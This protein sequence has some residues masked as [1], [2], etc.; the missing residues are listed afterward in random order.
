M[1]RFSIFIQVK[2]RGFRVEMREIVEAILTSAPKL[3]RA[4]VMLLD[5]Q[6]VAFVT[7]KL[8]AEEQS[9]LRR[10]LQRQLQDYMIPGRIIDLEAFPLN[11]NGKLDRQALIKIGQEEPN[12]SHAGHAASE[13][14]SISTPM[15]KLVQKTWAEILQKSPEE[16]NLQSNFFNVGGTSLSGI[17]AMR[18]LGAALEC[19]VPSTVAFS[20]QE[21][22]EQATELEKLAGIEAGGNIKGF[23]FEARG[24]SSITI[25]DKDGSEE[26]EVQDR[27]LPQ[28]VYGLLQTLGVLVVVAAGM[29]PAGGSIAMCL[30]LILE[31][32]GFAAL[33]LLPFVWMAGS[34]VHLLAAFLIKHILFGGRL[35]PG[36]YS[37]YGVTFLRWWLLRKLINVTRVWLWYVNNT[38]LNTAAY[39]FLGAHLESGVTLDD[40]VLEDLDLI[41]IEKN[42]VLQPLSSLIPGEIIGDVLILKP[43]V[44]GSNSKLEPRAAVLGGGKVGSN[45][46]V[47]PWSAVTSR[48]ATKEYVIMHGSPAEVASKLSSDSAPSQLRALYTN[49]A[50]FIIGQVIGTYFLIL[51]HTLGFGTSVAI[52]RVSR[53]LSVFFFFCRLFP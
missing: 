7:P 39:R 53:R 25:D 47:R 1:H 12:V 16:L 13:A 38:P 36:V 37:I 30:W 33:P 24:T 34:M 52:A 21:L 10:E 43:V 15:Q 35:R 14:V 32:I 23:D 48:S 9:A 18:R 22:G 4:E 41:T 8:L 46:I 40:A 49:S 31:A 17:L 50:V 28:L 20:A 11:K 44:V 45:S 19:Q 51:A 5:S 6:L 29:G 2:I 26:S 42:A 3:Q 27:P